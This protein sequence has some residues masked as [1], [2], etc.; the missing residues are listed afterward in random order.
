MGI[1]QPFGRDRL[2]VGMK[3]TL[4]GGMGVP[5]VIIN[6]TNGLRDKDINDK[7]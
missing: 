5:S 7:I 4:I 6:D 3:P 1:W 2:G